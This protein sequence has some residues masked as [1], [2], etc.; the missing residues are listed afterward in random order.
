M[1]TSSTH[2]PPNRTADVLDGVLGA[3]LA[4]AVSPLRS[5]RP[6]VAEHTQRLHDA[7]FGA[8]SPNREQLA[9]VALRAAVLAAQPALAEHY[10]ALLPPDLAAAVTAGTVDDPELA[11]LLRHAEL[12]T[13]DPAAATREAIER[14]RSAGLTEAAIVTVSQLIGYVNYQIRLVA[15]YTLI[16]ESA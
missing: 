4:D 2:A 1:T 8:P 11:A 16:G 7:F 5:A 12:L 3:P 10:S 9:A 13:V 14:L 6:A 15:G